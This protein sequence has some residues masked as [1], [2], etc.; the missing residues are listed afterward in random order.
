MTRRCLLS[1][2]LVLGVLLSSFAASPAQAQKRGFAPSGR[3]FSSGSRG[4]SFSRPVPSGR[5]YSSGG[6][7]FS[8]SPSAPRINIP[9]PAPSVRSST[10]SYQSG[11]GKSAM[12][13]APKI[14]TPTF[15]SPR[16]S[17]PSGKSYSSGAH[18]ASAP[19]PTP[20]PGGLPG[21]TFDKTA[22]EAQRKAESR[23]VFTRGQEPKPEYHDPEGK[24]HP[25][26]PQ[27]RQVEELRRQ[28]DYER[29]VN[30]SVR[31]HHYYGPYYGQPVVVYHDPFNS[32]FWYWLLSQDL[33]TRA[34]WAYNHH[35]AMDDARYQALLKHDAQLEARVRELEKK[36]VPPD[37]TY[38]PPGIDPDLMY[39]DNYVTSI[40]NPQ[41]TVHIWA[42]L[43]FLGKALVVLAI[44]AFM[45][46]LVFY[47]RWG[48]TPA[49]PT[50]ADS[51]RGGS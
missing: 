44:F 6:S 47:K 26:N 4:T 13:A 50:H 8:R 12:P 16:Q 2:F 27:S 24:P 9:N 17:A 30:R 46:W 10:K 20:T 7:S 28:L 39:T 23:R 40:Y 5:S 18:S 51:T 3:S 32:L 35:S 1:G 38:T 45:I 49:A 41:P 34:M 11:S 42:G 37:P 31:L 21:P 25:I 19:R 14:P 33:Q 22:A 36:G 29:W 43:V 48:G 15:P